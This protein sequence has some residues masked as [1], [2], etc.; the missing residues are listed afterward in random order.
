MH[1]TSRFQYVCHEEDEGLLANHHF[2]M[3]GVA[4]GP[5]STGNDPPGIFMQFSS[6]AKFDAFSISGA[7]HLFSVKAQ[8]RSLILLT[9][10]TGLLSSWCLLPMHMVSVLLALAS[11][12]VLLWAD[13]A[14]PFGWWFGFVLA[15]RAFC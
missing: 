7:A 1:P 10:V 4:C 12:R 14:F 6:P 5:S 2:G 11:L 9:F 8:N 15:T 3:R 13:V